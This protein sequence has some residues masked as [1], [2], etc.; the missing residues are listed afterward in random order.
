M[1]ILEPKIWVK[2]IVS[3]VQVSDFVFFSDS[4]NLTPETYLVLTPD[5]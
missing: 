1:W 5:T 4:R 3:D 2:A